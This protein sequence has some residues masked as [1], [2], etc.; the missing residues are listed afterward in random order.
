VLDI[1]LPAEMRDALAEQVA[2]T[3]AEQQQAQFLMPIDRGPEIT[4]TR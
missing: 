4:E 2:E 1:L 3:E